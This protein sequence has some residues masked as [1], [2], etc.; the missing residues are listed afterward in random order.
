MSTFR[1]IYVNLLLCLK[2]INYRLVEKQLIITE[3]WGFLCDFSFER[4]VNNY[5][6]AGNI[7]RTCDS[8][9][10]HYWAAI[11]KSVQ[12]RVSSMAPE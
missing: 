9:V 10:D 5:N 1:I 6:V 4:E 7:P 11:M 8:R 12:D 3:K 2:A